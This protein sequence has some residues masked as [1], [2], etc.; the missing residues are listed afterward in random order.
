MINQDIIGMRIPVNSGLAGYVATT[1][2]PLAISS[3]DNDARFNRSFAERS[4][5]IPNSVLTVP[6]LLGEKVIGVL[7]ALDKTSGETFG[8]KDIE[9]LSLFFRS[10]AGGAHL[11]SNIF[12][13]REKIDRSQRD[14]RKC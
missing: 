6:L 5:Y 10:M 13:L 12:V 7:Q 2:Q 11:C 14:K 1:G 4:G 9:L 3:A 8:L